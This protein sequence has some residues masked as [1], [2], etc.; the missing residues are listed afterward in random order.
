MIYLYIF[1]LHLVE[2]EIQTVQNLGQEIILPRYITNCF[3][4]REF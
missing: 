2:F 3:K 1:S 4:M